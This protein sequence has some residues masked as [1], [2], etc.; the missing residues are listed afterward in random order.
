MPLGRPRKPLVDRFW[1][2]VRKGDGCWSWLGLV[3]SRGY[4]LVRPGGSATKIAA[5]RVAW[6]FANGRPV[7][8]GMFVCHHCDN[9]RCV[10]ADHLFLGTA[11]DNSADMVAKGRQAKGEAFAHRGIVRGEACWNAKLSPAA[12]IEARALHLSGIRTRDIAGKFGVA[13]RTM[14]HALMGSTWKHLSGS[15]HILRRVPPQPQA[16]KK[17]KAA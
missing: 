7:P 5:H 8:P 11:A 15:E 16:K 1:S 9:R 17:R 4:G 13:L 3:S 10:R 2:L 14:Q 12:V 6:E